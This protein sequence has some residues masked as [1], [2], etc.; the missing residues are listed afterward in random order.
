[1]RHVLQLAESQESAAPLD[2]MDRAENA[3]HQFLR[4]W[5][6][7]ELHQLAI[8]A[9][10]VLIALDQEILDQIVHSRTLKGLLFADQPRN[11][12]PVALA[13]AR[14]TNC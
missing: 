2:R 9:I 4:R 1:M 11:P 12:A 13:H 8:E 7:F 10:Q 6:G 14:S 5:I 3:R